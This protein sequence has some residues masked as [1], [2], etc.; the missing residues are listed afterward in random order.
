[1]KRISIKSLHRK[2]WKPLTDFIKQRDGR[3]CFTCGKE[4]EPGK[5]LHCGHFIPSKI[6]GHELRYDEDIIHVQC[7]F[8]NIN[9]GGNGAIFYRRML[10]EYGEEKVNEIFIRLERYKKDKPKWEEIDY[11]NKIEYYKNKIKSK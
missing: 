9:L 5:G 2:L 8:C 7:Y 4:I 6:C 3:K 1:M 11:I 10:E